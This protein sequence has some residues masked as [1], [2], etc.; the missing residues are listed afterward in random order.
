MH[1]SL[2]KAASHVARESDITVSENI[3][4]K[5]FTDYSTFVGGGIP[6]SVLQ[7][8]YVF[9]VRGTEV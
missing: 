1:F 4:L 9:D 6:Q 7:V 2:L 8:G 3:V 5:G